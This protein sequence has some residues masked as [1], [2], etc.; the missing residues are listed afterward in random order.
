M[1]K[2]WPKDTDILMNWDEESLEELQ[3]PTLVVEAEK[4]YSEFMQSWNKLYKVL[5][6]YPDYF[7]PES[8]QLYRYKW[9]TILTTN[10]CF[11]SNWPGV[12]Q[13]VPFADQINHEN[14]NVNYDCLDPKT[15]ESLMSKEEQMQKMKQEEM[16]K[17]MKK[18]EFLSD[19]KNDLQS[20]SDK[21]NE[22][23]GVTG[24]PSSDNT[25][26]I[27]TKP[28][29]TE[30]IDE[31]TNKLKHELQKEQ[32]GKEPEDV[33]S[34]LESDNDLDLLVEQ[35]VLQA[36]KLRKQLRRQLNEKE[37]SGSSSS[38]EENDKEEEK[39]SESK[40]AVSET[41]PPAKAKSIHDLTKDQVYKIWEYTLK[42]V[43]TEYDFV[44]KS[45]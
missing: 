30:T 22:H 6:Q 44:I 25:W 32:E 20:L 24:V 39:T 18:K 9:V 3:D 7:K 37:E 40:L 35:E 38:D 10:R 21:V 8:I 41:Q 34:G 36:M 14:V 26:R 33:S 42:D 23:F 1:I 15:G 13:M 11:S 12:C 17:E 4:Q 28:P 43:P 45:Q 16:E 19:L 29:G 2:M 27:C 5:S 31:Q